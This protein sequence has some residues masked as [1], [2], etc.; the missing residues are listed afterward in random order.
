L[1]A[2]GGQKQALVFQSCHQHV[3]ND[4]MIKREVW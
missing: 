2:I 3:I 4:H 1:H